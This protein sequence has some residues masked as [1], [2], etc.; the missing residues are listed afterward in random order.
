MTAPLNEARIAVAQRVAL[1]VP[2]YNEASRL[3]F[4]AF[5]AW[6][7]SGVL[8]VFVDDGSTDD[9]H[10]RLESVFRKR[11][12]VTL[13]R[14]Q[15]NVGK[16][17]AVRMGL[18]YAL[19]N[20]SDAEWYGFWDADL[21]APPDQLAVLLSYIPMYSDERPCALWGSRLKR[22]GADIR[23]SQLRHL[24]GRGFAFMSSMLLGVHAYDTQCGAKLFDRAVVQ[25]CF[26]E[27]F[28]TDWIFD[29]ELLLRLESGAVIECPLTKWH[30]RGS[31]RINFTKLMIKLPMHMAALRR[32]YVARAE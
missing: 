21:S 14:L 9:T 10:K 16:A 1:V 7:Q 24:L 22:L 15:K 18:L 5:E 31:S 3:D 20:F 6:A 13:M 11:A 25:K 19:E 2:C 23:R 8:L 27:P 32:R 29:L 4:A 26:A 17:E 28:L 30:A 12:N